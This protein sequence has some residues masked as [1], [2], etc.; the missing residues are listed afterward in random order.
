[1][2]IMAD[3]WRADFLGCE[4]T[5]LVQTPFLDMLSAR[6]TQMERAYSPAPTCVPARRSLFT[7]LTPRSHGVVGYKDGVPLP[8]QTTLAQCFTQAGYQTQAI[9]KMHMHPARHRAGFENVLL[10]DGYLHYARRG[11]PDVR[12]YDDYAA[13]LANQADNSAFV[14][15]Y[16]NGVH[17]NAVD[18]RPW[19][20]PE[21]Q[22]PT[23]WVTNEAVN[24]LYRRDPQQ[25]FFLY[26][27]YHR[28]HAPYNPPQWAWDLYEDVD[29]SMQEI[30]GNWE[31]TLLSKHR[32]VQDNQ[33][34]VADYPL[35]LRKRALQGYLGNIT[36][37]D[38]QIGR[39]I[40]AIV[41]FG[42]ADDTIICF[43]S[44]HG[45]MIGEH[46]MWRKGYPY[47]GSARVPMI[48]AGPG[49]VANEKKTT[50]CDLVDV[51]PT[52]LDLAGVTVP[53]EIDGVSHAAM[54]QDTTANINPARQICHG[55]H[56]IFGQSL[57]WMIN[58]RYKYIWWSGDGTEQLFDLQ[59][60]PQEI[61]DLL[62]Q[63][64]TSISSVT[65]VEDAYNQLKQAII[66]W[67]TDRPEGFV[68]DGKLQVGCE[69]QVVL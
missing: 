11:R 63:G 20:R 55:E 46:G 56:V 66:L 14:D 6:G 49:I 67:L 39:F 40:E 51:M 27:S 9:G 5:T 62:M 16:E 2:L 64:I 37:V 3:Q 43:T 8:T 29:T 31:E 50:I 26:L 10:H 32:N 45:D 34:H 7:G 28:P 12:Y 36:H 52:L 17:C 53:S 47:E 58:D 25:P 33:A 59:N 69:T 19:D 24:W 57:Q 18:A 60:D 15:E 48:F 21:A 54:L 41:D 23:N 1:M 38:A 42:I 13:W 44:D 22:H 65:E 4:N 30:R 61:E 68:V 35:Q